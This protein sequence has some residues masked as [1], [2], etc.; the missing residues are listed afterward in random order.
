MRK[1]LLIMLFIVIVNNDNTF[2]KVFDI[3]K[4]KDVKTVLTYTKDTLINDIDSVRFGMYPQSDATG[5]RME[6]I[7]WIV[8]HISE[9]KKEALL[10][11]KYILDNKSYYHYWT[12]VV[13]FES[14]LRKWLNESFY[15]NAFNDKEKERI[16]LKETKNNIENS[17]GINGGQDS[18]DKIFCLSELECYKY[19]N[20]DKEQAKILATNAT[21]YAKN[22][23]NNGEKLNI[24][25]GP[26]IYT[27]E[28]SY[29]ESSIILDIIFSILDITFDFFD[30]ITY[31]D[32]CRNNSEYWLRTPGLSASINTDYVMTVNWRGE[33]WDRQVHEKNVGVRPAMWIRIE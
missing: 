29:P 31:E 20:I 11:S 18:K 14:D 15:N 22:F 17:F 12:D 23:D 3:D 1:S 24:A 9:D 27:D 4:I 19:F 2:A 25:N 26:R 6:P 28:H 32:W 21:E 13:W 7:E 33:I 8:L 30:K 10:L 16:L 5:E